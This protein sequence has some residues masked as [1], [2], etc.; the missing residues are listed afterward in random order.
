M[1]FAPLAFSLGVQTSGGS[2]SLTTLIFTFSELTNKA[3][4][5]VWLILGAGPSVG[6]VSAEETFST[7]TVS[8]TNDTIEM[9]QCVAV[10]LINDLSTNT[11]R[12]CTVNGPFVSVFSTGSRF[13]PHIPLL[14]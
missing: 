4:L 1:D 14:R 5:S 9:R 3:L 10:G 11:D 8:D 6:N 13:D 7:D 12:Y 2:I